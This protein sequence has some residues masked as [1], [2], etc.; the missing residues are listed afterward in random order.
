MSFE[1]HVYDKEML[2]V[3]NVI[4]VGMTSMFI[5]KGEGLI[6]WFAWISHFTVQW[7]FAPIKQE[8][9][10]IRH[11]WTDHCRITSRFWYGLKENT[12]VY[13]PLESAVICICRSLFLELINIKFA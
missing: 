2:F 3:N 10:D 12:L 9:P 4:I 1:V 6:F 13:T 11:H 5:S 8:G 7:L